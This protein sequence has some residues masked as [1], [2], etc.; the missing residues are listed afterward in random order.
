MTRPMLTLLLCFA[1]VAPALAQ[2]KRVVTVAVAANMKPAFEEIAAAF[3]KANPAV[4]VS[5]T[6]GA[7]GTFLAQIANGAPFDLFLSAD[8]EFPAKAVEK[9]LAAGAPFPYAYGK[10]VVWAPKGT[11]PDLEKQ[12]LAAL[13]ASS[14]QKIAI[15]NPDVAP[16]GRAAR[17][18]LE[19]AGLLD[20]VKDRLVMGQSVS[21]AAQF[22]ESGNAQAAFLPLS[23]TRVPP[24]SQAGRAWTVPPSLYDRVEQS[25]V[26]LKAARQPELARAL[27]A[28]LQGEASRTILA[29]YGYELPS[30]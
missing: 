3:R 11:L 30:R 16:Y 14:V 28:F 21:Q 8:S 23:L 2:E 20:A 15:A 19:K 22:V 18:A 7:S 1:M 27:A 9:G 24:L 25:G 6:Y 10:L 4:E 5:A 17:A 12:G 13:A 29:R 26:V